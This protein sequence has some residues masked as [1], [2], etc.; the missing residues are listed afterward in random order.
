M[1]GKMRAMH[2]MQ[3]M[4]CGLTTGTVGAEVS[5]CLSGQGDWGK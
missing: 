3:V 4:R 5:A 1:G 2:Q